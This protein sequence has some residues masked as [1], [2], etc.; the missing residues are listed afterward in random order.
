MGF[1]VQFSG[2]R[3]QGYFDNNG[4]E[5]QFWTST[6]KNK[7][8]YT[9]LFKKADDRICKN[10][11]GEAYSCN[12]RCIKNDTTTNDIKIIQIIGSEKKG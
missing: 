9:R 2:M 12:V 1:D 6:K 8:T 5:A 3:K 11:L 4:T 10:L 7:P